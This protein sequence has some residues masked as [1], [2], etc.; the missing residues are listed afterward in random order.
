MSLSEQQPRIWLLLGDKKGDN[1]QVETIAE[2]I[3]S[4]LGW[5]CERKRIKVLEPFVFGKPGSGR[6]STI[7]SAS[8]L[9]HSQHP[10]RI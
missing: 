8:S 9:I 7:S 2:A 4:S 1:G 10:G 5:H 6:R 3:E